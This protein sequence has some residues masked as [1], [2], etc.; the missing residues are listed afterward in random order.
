LNDQG[1]ESFWGWGQGAQGNGGCVGGTGQICLGKIKND[2]NL[3]G[4]FIKKKKKE[5]TSKR[6]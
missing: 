1:Y 4:Y 5:L 6:G 3:P 2:F